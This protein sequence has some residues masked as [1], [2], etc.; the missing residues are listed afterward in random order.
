MSAPHTPATGWQPWYVPLARRLPEK[1]SCVTNQ[2]C[3]SGCAIALSAQKRTLMPVR[4]SLHRR[5]FS[6][7]ITTSLILPRQRLLR[8]HPHRHL[9]IRLPPLPKLT[10]VRL[11][12]SRRQ[13]LERATTAPSKRALPGRNGL[14]GAAIHAGGGGEVEVGGAAAGRE[15]KSSRRQTLPTQAQPR[16]FSRR[17]AP[18][19][20]GQQTY[21]RP[22]CRSLRRARL[23]SPLAC[24]DRAR[25][26]GSNAI[27]SLLYR[28]TC[29]GRSCLTIPRNNVSRI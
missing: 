23:F 26:P 11:T 17:V 15:P 27:T 21:Q 22:R 12:R 13:N 24:R 20:P 25:A 16:M 3:A 18:S 19:L 4:A 10:N 29:C 6:P 8:N 7:P 14:T 28:V 9:P 1:C 5:L 2:R